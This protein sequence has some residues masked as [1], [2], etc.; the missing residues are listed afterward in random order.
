MLLTTNSVGSR[1]A[2]KEDALSGIGKGILMQKCRRGLSP[3][4]IAHNSE[5]AGAFKLCGRYLG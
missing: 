3:L 4:L 1:G 5:I 2:K